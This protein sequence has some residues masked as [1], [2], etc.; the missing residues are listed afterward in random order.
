MVFIYLYWKDALSEKPGEFCKHKSSS[1]YNQDVEVKRSGH[2][3]LVEVEVEVIYSFPRS[4]RD[5]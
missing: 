3:R 1:L 2:A 4:R 5:A